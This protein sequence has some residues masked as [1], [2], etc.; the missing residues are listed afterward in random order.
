MLNI[1]KGI[2]EIRKETVYQKNY[3]SK[4]LVIYCI[5]ST[6]EEINQQLQNCQFQ[7]GK[8]AKYVFFKNTNLEIKLG[9]LYVNNL[10]NIQVKYEV[11]HNISVVETIKFESKEHSLRDAILNMKI[12]QN[13]LFVAAK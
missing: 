7:S 11:L 8:Y 2:V 5:L 3:E 9:T 13:N 4:C 10:N 12:G 6:W 1:T